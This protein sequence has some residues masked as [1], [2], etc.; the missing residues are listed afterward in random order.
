MMPVPV[1]SL[2]RSRAVIRLIRLAVPVVLATLA[3]G[4][5]PAMAATPVAT[6]LA[7]LVVTVATPRAWIVPFAP[8]Y[9]EPDQGRL[10]FGVEV[11][12]RSVE[13]VAVEVTFR[14]YAADGT[15]FA[16]CSRMTPFDLGSGAAANIPPHETAWITC[17]SG[18]VELDT[19]DLTATARI[20]DVEPVWTRPG[21]TL[22]VEDYGFALNEDM[23]DPMVNA[24]DAFAVVA[25][26]GDED[27]AAHLWFLFYDDRGVLVGTC[28]SSGFSE[29]VVEPEVAQRVTCWFP[30]IIDVASPQPV[31]VRVVVRPPF[32]SVL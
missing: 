21:P 25:A 5:V 12:N 8:G 24:Y 10:Y 3:I 26:T 32:S 29:I 27:V 17:D 16:D 4:F 22:A 19:G 28:D 18:P 20:R 31:S 30:M 9:G 1:S 2:V 13:T 15:I 6:P 11:E 7:D 14:G 23:T